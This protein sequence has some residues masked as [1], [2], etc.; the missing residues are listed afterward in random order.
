MNKAQLVELIAKKT[1]STKMQA[2][3]FLDATL[4][5]IKETLK[6]GE[7]VKLVGFGNF[8]RS[9]RKAKQGRNPKT[10]DTLVIPAAYTPKFK[11]GKDLKDYLNS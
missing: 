7:E 1:Q 2:E 10:G 4:E 5:S 8:S 6:E 11:P 9:L 3:L